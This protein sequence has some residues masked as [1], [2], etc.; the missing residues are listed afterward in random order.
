MP[1]ALTLDI[2]EDLYGQYN[3]R[4]YADP[5]P[6]LFLYRYDDPADREVVALIASSLAYGKVA[7]I[8]HSIEAVV[9]PMGNRPAAY[10]R[11]TP[12]PS[13]KKTFR[14]F[15]HRWTTG[16]ELASFLS[17]I[18]G[19]LM[20]H[21]SLE[22]CFLEGLK[23]DEP[24]LVPA[25]ALFVDQ[26]NRH[27]RGPSPASLL[28]L[29]MRGS[30]SKRLH[31]F[32]RWMARRDAVDPGGWDRVPRSKL[33]VPLDTHMH[34][35]G[36]RL[37]WTRRK[38]AGLRTAVDVTDA[39]RRFSPDDPVKYDFSL[40]RLGIRSDADLAGFLRRCGVGESAT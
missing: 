29:P 25:L 8:L 38:Q 22:A 17:G 5:D 24:T 21:G 37:E 34:R 10:L 19:V 32:L 11:A 27:S 30:A 15:K 31:L 23:P 1:P 2:L 39:L 9:G 12:W 28:P 14:S 6:I 16:E 36:L 18:R 33:L 13:L 4:R 7:H 20:R 26:V 40:T 35:M 3:H